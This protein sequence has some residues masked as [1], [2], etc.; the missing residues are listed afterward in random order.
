MF[1][2]H[3]ERDILAIN[4]GCNEMPSRPTVLVHEMTHLDYVGPFHQHTVDYGDDER[5]YSFERVRILTPEQR[6][7]HAATYEFFAQSKP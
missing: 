1:F 5:G 2:S 6:L 3:D 4:H 7:Y